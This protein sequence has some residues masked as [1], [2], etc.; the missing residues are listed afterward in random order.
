[1]N[2]YRL[3]GMDSGDKNCTTTIRQDMLTV[4]FLELIYALNRR[5]KI[6]KVNMPLSN[7]ISAGSSIKVLNLKF[8][9]DLKLCLNMHH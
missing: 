8:L 7:L 9:P 1:M 5:S 2:L 4:I 3:L 6:D